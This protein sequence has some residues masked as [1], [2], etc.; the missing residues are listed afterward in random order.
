MCGSIHA[1]VADLANFS[2]FTGLSSVELQVIAAQASSVQL[3]AVQFVALEGEEPEHIF[4]IRDAQVE[5]VKNAAPG[6]TQ[7]HR[8]AILEKGDSV[9]EM[10]LLDYQSRSAS[11]RT[12]APSTFYVL[13]LAQLRGLKESHNHIY[14]IIVNNVEREVCRRLRYTTEVTVV[15]LRETLEQAR[16]R[17]LMGHFLTNIFVILCFYALIAGS[18]AS[19]ILE[20]STSVFYISF[21]V[22][23]HSGPGDPDRCQTG[24]PVFEFFR[25]YRVQLEISSSRS[26]D[27][28]ASNSCACGDREVDHD[29]A[30]YLFPPRGFQ[31]KVSSEPDTWAVFTAVG[32]L[33]CP[34][35]RPRISGP[36][37]LARIASG[38]FDGPLC[39]LES[40][41]N[42]E[43]VVFDVACSPVTQVRGGSFCAGDS[44]GLALF[45]SPNIDRRNYLSR[46]DRCVDFLFRWSA[47]HSVVAGA[48]H[49]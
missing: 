19:M 8:V 34:G 14:R 28:D 44:L 13:S 1:P 23:R 4:L 37:S 16:I 38:I 42:F 17:T 49:S 25:T 33:Y 39:R 45:P 35:P 32:N 15:S 40:D 31:R 24:A 48:L 9:G 26:I 7:T 29:S 11:A 27:V 10:A 22:N 46:P 12:L 3:P 5:I 43:F 18:I 6:P 36:R 21:S 30:S 20:T 2:L 47:R 41:S